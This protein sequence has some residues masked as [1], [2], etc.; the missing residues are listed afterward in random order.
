MFNSLKLKFKMVPWAKLI[1]FFSAYAP[2][3]FIMGVK[4]LFQSK[5]YFPI[6]LKEFETSVPIISLIIFGFVIVSITLFNHV[7]KSSKSEEE[8]FIE[9][10]KIEEKNDVIL[11]YL[12][13]YFFSFSSINSLEEIICGGM[14]FLIILLIY[15][16]SEI[17]YINP[18]FLA[19]QY[20]F[21]NIYTDDGHVLLISKTDLN[22]EIGRK[23]PVNKLTTRVYIKG[24]EYE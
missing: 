20:S 23:I 5:F 18:I 3:L 12:I 19:Q 7:I 16:K 9:V 2:L 24:G 8:M 4:F 6:K 1:L 11:T 15:I 14:I 22:R 13:P 10:S 17:L 21:Y